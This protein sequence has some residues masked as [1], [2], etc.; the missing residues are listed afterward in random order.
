[1][2]DKLADILERLERVEAAVAG[3]GHNGVPLSAILRPLLIPTSKRRTGA[4]LRRWSRSAMAEHAQLS[5][6]LRIPLK[7][8]ETRLRSQSPLL[9]VVRAA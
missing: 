3:I 6:G 5:A 1:M 2:T 4:Y 8:P 7:F 9:V